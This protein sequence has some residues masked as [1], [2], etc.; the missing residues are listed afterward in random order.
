MANH[1]FAYDGVGNPNSPN[2]YTRMTVAPTCTSGV[3]ICAVYLDDNSLGNPSTLGPVLNYISNAQATLIPQPQ[4][5]VIK[6]YVYLKS[7]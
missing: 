2:S 4:D 7:V 5:G 3:D 1:W 6:R